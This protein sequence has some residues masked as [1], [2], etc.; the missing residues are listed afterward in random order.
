MNC[1]LLPEN[2]PLILN[3]SS[4]KLAHIK[5]V[6]KARENDEIFAANLNA[7]LQ[8]CRINYTSQGGAILTPIRPAPIAPLLNITL[9]VSYSRPQI[10]QR[11]L[12]D[13]ACFGVKHLVFYPATKGE[14]AYAQ[15]SLYLNDEYKNWLIKGAEQACASSIP[16]FSQSSSLENA[17]ELSAQISPQASVRTAPDV[18]EATTSLNAFATF[19]SQAKHTII[20]FG[21]ERGFANSDRQILRQ[22]NFTLT[23][24]GK[25]VLRTD[26][27]IIAALGIYAAR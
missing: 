21:S 10:A 24:L 19:H 23:S 16:T 11:I 14:S 13:A 18:Y 9:A 5:D 27:A 25:R 7:P 20:L 17:I 2:S 15:S 8:I 12:F 26:S 22:N 3:P 4:P 6:I 1:L